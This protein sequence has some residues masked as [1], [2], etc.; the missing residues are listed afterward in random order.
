MAAGGVGAV[1]LASCNL[2]VRPVT[3]ELVEP[4]NTPVSPVGMG[5]GDTDADG[6]PD[7]VVTGREGYAVLT[8]DGTGALTLDVPSVFA[9]QNTR[10]FLV[11]V[12]GD[13]DLDL[14]SGVVDALY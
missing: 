5:T 14:V 1:A 3:Y 6:D 11:D 8:N 12:D 10:P 13:D 4:D 7:V 2:G 9:P